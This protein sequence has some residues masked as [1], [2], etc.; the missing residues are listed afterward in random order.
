MRPKMLEKSHSQIL[1]LARNQSTAVLI[2]KEKVPSPLTQSLVIY[3]R[4]KV[5]TKDRDRHRGATKK[6]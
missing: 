1:P 2:V 5:S 3:Q 6:R 4:N